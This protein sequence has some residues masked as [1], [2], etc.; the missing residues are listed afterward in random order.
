[1]K[2]KEGIFGGYKANVIDCVGGR[3]KHMV[4]F[5]AVGHGHEM[6]SSIVHGL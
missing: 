5:L 6:E 1:M 4:E 2:S 3:T